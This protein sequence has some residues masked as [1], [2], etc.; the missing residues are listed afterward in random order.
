M[1]YEV[2]W[3]WWASGTPFP[4]FAARFPYKATN[5]KKGALTIRWLPGYQ[6][7]S[8]GG[9]WRL[10]GCSGRFRRLKGL[11]EG[12]GGGLGVRCSFMVFL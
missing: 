9:F 8:Q 10:K 6:V 5:P 1:S 12:R 2:Y 7:G 11:V 4:C 3:A